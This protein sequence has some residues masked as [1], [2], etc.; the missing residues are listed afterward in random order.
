MKEGVFCSP[1]CKAATALTRPELREI[2]LV[3]KLVA[4]V[5]HDRQGSRNPYLGILTLL[6]AKEIGNAS[7]AVSERI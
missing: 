5:V 4:G 3:G 7:S 1:N 2:E 6:G